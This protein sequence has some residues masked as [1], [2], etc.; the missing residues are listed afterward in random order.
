[1]K[2][3]DLPTRKAKKNRLQNYIKIDNYHSFNCQKGNFSD[4]QIL[5]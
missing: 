2:A 1:M 3:K 4:I 5:F